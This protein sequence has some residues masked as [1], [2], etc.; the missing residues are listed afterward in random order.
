MSCRHPLSSSVLIVLLAL[1]CEASA[2]AQTTSSPV[3]LPPM[4]TDMGDTSHT[5]AGNATQTYKLTYSYG[6]YRVYDNPLTQYEV[7]PCS[8]KVDTALH[9]FSDYRYTDC[10]VDIVTY[11]DGRGNDTRGVK[12][13]Y[14]CVAPAPVLL[15]GG[16]SFDGT[17]SQV[18]AQRYAPAVY[19]AADEK[20]LPSSID[21]YA[22]YVHMECNGR[23]TFE[24]L[25]KITTRDLPTNGGG[26]PNGSDQ[27]Q[28]YFVPK[29]ELTGPYDQ[30]DWLKGQDPSAVP[31][32][33][34][35]Y[36]DSRDPP[37]NYNFIVQYMLFFPYNEGKIACMTFAPLDNCMDKRVMM[38]DHVADWEIMSIRFVNGIP[39]SVHVGA[40]KNDQPDMADTYFCCAWTPSG[41][42]GGS[43][44]A[45]QWMGQ[46]PV[47]YTATGSHGTWATAEQH[48]YASI[49]TG[50]KLN[51]YT[52]AGK[53]WKTWEKMVWFS[54]D[55]NDSIL[56]L[57]NDY[58]G[59]WGAHHLGKDACTLS[60]GVLCS[61]L[62]IPD[63]EYQL[64]DGPT[65]PSRDR[66]RNYLMAAPAP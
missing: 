4:P 29:Q 7:I 25:T 36:T 27:V 15:K 62:G 35:V 33:V 18:L 17:W 59:R 48:N 38:D 31:V 44:V 1:W 45:L 56:V 39:Q 22:Q 34:N 14:A 28:C 6:G 61:Y 51:D 63:D 40:H 53:L 43:E 8:D 21:Y 9:I 50:D 49:S 20:W 64:N 47:V 19:L 55:P 32:Y 26:R 5:C 16:N 2:F 58:E 30:P 3:L 60:G 66:D 10:L 41:K 46:H 42:A 37:S 65:L 13:I 11:K 54:W 57:L 12:R 24:N 23:I 52:S